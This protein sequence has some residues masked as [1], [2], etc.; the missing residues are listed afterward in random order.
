MTLAAV[1]IAPI[2]SRIRL[3]AVIIGL[4]VVVVVV[5]FVMLWLAMTMCAA[6]VRCVTG[7]RK[8]YGNYNW[9]DPRS[10]QHRTLG[11]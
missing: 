9:S 2:K 1:G 10:L 4:T 8:A 3:L 11:G 7:T 5:V 6:N